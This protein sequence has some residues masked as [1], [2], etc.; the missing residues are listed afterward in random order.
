MA[1]KGKE[2]S[3]IWENARKRYGCKHEFLPAVL[4]DH[5]TNMFLL[6]HSPIGTGLNKA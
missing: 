3:K 1:D 5:V 4:P 2:K 6:E